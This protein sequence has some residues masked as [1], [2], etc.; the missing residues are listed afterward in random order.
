MKVNFFKKERKFP[1]LPVILGALFLIFLLL[2]IKAMGPW[3]FEKEPPKKIVVERNPTKKISGLSAVQPNQTIVK[4][5]DPL[6]LKLVQAAQWGNIDALKKLLDQGVD[7]NARDKYGRVPLVEAA[8]EGRLEVIKLLLAHG[9]DI[10]GSNERGLTALIASAR[11]GD[12]EIVRL[13]VENGADIDRKYTSVFVGESSAL[14]VAMDEKRTEIVMYLLE[15]QDNPDWNKALIWAADGPTEVVRTLI[16]K[17]ADLKKCAGQCMDSAI[18]RNRV[19]TIKFF[20]EKGLD[21]NGFIG[22][23]DGSESFLIQAVRDG[24]KEIV[25]LLL[26]K[27]I[28]AD[29]LNKGALEAEWSR[30]WASGIK[31]TALDIAREYGEEEIVELLEQA[32]AISKVTSKPVESFPE[33]LPSETKKEP[34][35]PNPLFTAIEESDIVALKTLLENGADPN[36]EDR[37]DGKLLERAIAKGDIEAIKLLLEKGADA[38]NWGVLNSALHTDTETHPNIEVVQLLL[39]HGARFTDDDLSGMAMLGQRDVAE[40]LIKAGANP[41]AQYKYGRTD[42]M[43]AAAAGDIS[44]LQVLLNEGVYVNEKNDDGLTPLSIAT[45]NGKKETVEFLIENGA[46]FSLHDDRGS[47]PLEYAARGNRTETV[48]LLIEKGAD[49]N[50]KNSI[51]YSILSIAVGRDSDSE[52]IKMLLDS[53]ADPNFAEDNGFTILMRAARDS[54]A[55]V[56]Q[57]L[58]DYGADLQAKDH[59]ETVI[60]MVTDR[61]KRISDPKEKKRLEE[62]LTVLKEAA[63]Q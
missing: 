39:D 54:K 17:G 47:T 5:V 55:D 30:A 33:T 60:Q 40:L 43:L 34:N 58:L 41:K 46:D 26:D 56:V 44:Q 9:A 13:L 32:G 6:S 38:K 25:K 35:L 52:T 14:N 50:G 62:I 27:G 7:I 19:E 21:P 51:G 22:F 49:P 31:R 20:L 59:G 8:R 1:L 45:W 28:Q 16:E 57:L 18:F 42:F 29:I 23:R 3:V 48:K 36:K 15:K 24:R 2:R 53:G 10:N 4:K 37:K 12:I 63:G 61:L 11:S